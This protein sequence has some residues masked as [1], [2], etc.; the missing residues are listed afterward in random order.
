MTDSKDYRLYL[1]EHFKRVD[2]HFEGQTKL[3]NAQ[4]DLVYDKLDEIKEETSCT[5][6]RVTHLEEEKKQYLKT[7]VDLQMLKNVTDKIDDVDKKINDID[8]NLGEYYIIKK[9]PKASLILLIVFILSVL[10]GGWGTFKSA[11]NSKSNKELIKKIEDIEH[12]L[13]LINN[14]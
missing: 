8:K 14:D 12:E 13:K 2:D 4:F 5:N 7:R 11:T 1:E 10:I 3:V 9:Y 6:S